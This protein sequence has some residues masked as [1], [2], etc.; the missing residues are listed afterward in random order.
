MERQRE[1][2]FKKN[3][4]MIGKSLEVL[5][6]AEDLTKGILKG[7]LK[8][9]APEIDGCVF[10]KGEAKPGDQVMARIKKAYPYDLMGKIETVSR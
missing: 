1:I 5:V 10:L 9:Q 2:S 4:A 7:R 6:D 8:T 3:K